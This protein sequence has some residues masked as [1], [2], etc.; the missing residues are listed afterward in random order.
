MKKIVLVCVI[1]TLVCFVSCVKKQIISDKTKS[2]NNR[3]LCGDLPLV[4]QTDIPHRFDT[5]KCTVLKDSVFITGYSDTVTV[6][7]Y[8]DRN[9]KFH[10]ESYKDHSSFLDIWDLPK[11]YTIR[12]DSLGRQKSIKIW[13]LEKCVF[14]ELNFWEGDEGMSVFYCDYTKT[15]ECYE[16]Q[17]NRGLIFETRYIPIIKT[18][19]KF[20]ELN[21]IS[22]FLIEKNIIPTK[23]I[24]YSRDSITGRDTLWKEEILPI[25]EYLRR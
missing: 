16:K 10:N 15:D 8:A 17:Y 25:E 12:Y 5:N 11:S 14:K 2:T 6:R 20:D 3:N 19:Y 4:Y 18:K 22:H 1:L 21:L 13:D 7:F 9:M 24:T 23:R